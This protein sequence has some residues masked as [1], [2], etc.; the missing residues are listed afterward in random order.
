MLRKNIFVGNLKCVLC[1]DEAP[2]NMMHL[3]FQCDFSQKI[4]WRIEEEWNTELT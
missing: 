3:F 1:E 2:E 4:W